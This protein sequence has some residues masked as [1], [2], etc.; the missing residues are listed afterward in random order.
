[1]YFYILCKMSTNSVHLNSVAGEI[2]LFLDFLITYLLIFYLKY[3]MLLYTFNWKFRGWYNVNK[4]IIWRFLFFSV[5]ARKYFYNLDVQWY[6]YHCIYIY[7][8]SY[9]RRVWRYQ[10]WTCSS[11]FC[12]FFQLYY[13]EN[14]LHLMRWWQ[15]LCTIR[16]CWFGFV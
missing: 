2:S 8:S 3:N 14:K 15:T 12:T 1:M 6:V 4:M 7:R 9:V 13:E 11:L 16:A 10:R 5:W